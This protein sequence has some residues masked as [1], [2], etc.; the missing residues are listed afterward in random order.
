MA[1]ELV[2]DGSTWAH[3]KEGYR[4]TVEHSAPQGNTL[5]RREAGLPITYR[6]GVIKTV[7][8]LRTKKTGSFLKEFTKV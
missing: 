6:N 5:F 7:A 8:R 1:S 4:V 3:T 2:K